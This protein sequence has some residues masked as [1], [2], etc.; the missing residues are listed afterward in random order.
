[1]VVSLL[2]NIATVSLRYVNH[3][4]GRALPFRSH[5]SSG[6]NITNMVTI[7]V[8]PCV[9][10]HADVKMNPYLH[11]QPQSDLDCAK[12]VFYHCHS[13]EDSVGE[14]GHSHNNDQNW[15]HLLSLFF[16]LIY[17][18][19]S[20]T[21]VHVTLFYQD[22]HIIAGRI[23]MTKRVMNWNRSPLEC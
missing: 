5:V 13:D 23:K 11:H 17:L 7:I 22:F 8:R 6:E 1:M 18:F 19:L 21:L 10:Y 2:L 4:K 12:E 16:F 14:G 9:E 3:N 15:K 20:L